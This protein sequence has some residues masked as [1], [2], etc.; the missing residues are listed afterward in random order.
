MNCKFSCIKITTGIFV[1]SNDRW[2]IIDGRWPF[3]RTL[4]TNIFNGPAIFMVDQDRLI[5]ISSFYPLWTLGS[6][7]SKKLVSAR[8]DEYSLSSAMQPSSASYKV[9]RKFHMSIELRL[10][11]CHFWL[12][13]QLTVTCNYVFLSITSSN[14]GTHSQLVSNQH[15]WTQLTN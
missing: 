14:N 1:C 10:V 11:A 12:K 4:Q 7:T 6:R 3:K 9:W 8:K 5:K 15:L 13:K 2:N